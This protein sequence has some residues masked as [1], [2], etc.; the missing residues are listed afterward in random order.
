MRDNLLRIESDDKRYDEAY[1]LEKQE[2]KLIKLLKGEGHWYEKMKRVESLLGDFQGN[3]I[4]DLGTQI[5]TY[6][7]YLSKKS[8]FSVGVDFAHEPLKKAKELSYRL[9]IKNTRFVQAN[10]NELPFPEKSFDLVIG[11][12]IVE[13]LV[14]EDLILSLK[15][16]YRVLKDD[17][18]LVLQTYPNRYSY[19]FLKFNKYSLIPI[20]LFWL[21]K[22]LFSKTIDKYHQIVTFSKYIKYKLIKINPKGTHINCQTLESISRTVEDNRFLVETAFAENSYSI[23]ERT[24][25]SK[26]MEKILRDNIVTKQNIYLKC[27]KVS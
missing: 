10:V 19:C 25:F 14:H 5:G 26:F 12:D 15:E 2:K 1:L 16:S 8:K 13:H 3:K 9:L 4:L 6:A 18:I 24:K 7:I 27:K 11:C 22:E 21:P 23:Y 17:G 20:L